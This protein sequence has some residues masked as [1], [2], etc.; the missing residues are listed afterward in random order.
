[1]DRPFA[2]VITPASVLLRSRPRRLIRSASSY[3]PVLAQTL[4]RAGQPGPTASAS[5]PSTPST[6]KASLKTAYS[7]RLLIARSSCTVARGAAP[8][9]AL[10]PAPRRPPR[11]GAG[12]APPPPPATAR[13]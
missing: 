13:R 7:G 12:P 9:G 4:P 2:V 5:V 10:S 6:G 3:V 8:A 1:S 11:A